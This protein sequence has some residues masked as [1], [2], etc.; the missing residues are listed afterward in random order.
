MLD[1]ARSHRLHHRISARH[2]GEGASEPFEMVAG[3]RVVSAHVE[4]RSTTGLRPVLHTS[5]GI[6]G[7]RRPAGRMQLLHTTHVNRYAN[8]GI[9][10]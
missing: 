3:I 9:M 7:Q 6:C 5:H 4:K 10:R 8:I 1:L 2:E